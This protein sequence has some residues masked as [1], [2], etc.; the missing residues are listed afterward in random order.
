M[1]NQNTLWRQLCQ[2]EII[3]VLFAQSALS[4]EM[5]LAGCGAMPWTCR[6]QGKGT[7]ELIAERDL[8]LFSQQNSWVDPVNSLS[9]CHRQGWLILCSC[10]DQSLAIASAKYQGNPTDNWSQALCFK[11]NIS[12]PKDIFPVAWQC[13][14]RFPSKFTSL[15]ICQDHMPKIQLCLL[16]S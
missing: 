1:Q 3:S 7:G 10:D 12:Q 8:L 5:A 13:P 16:V 4:A 2:E 14:R 9:L 6:K 11:V 15:P